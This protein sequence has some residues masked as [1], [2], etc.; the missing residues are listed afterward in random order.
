[1]KKSDRK[2]IQT[3]IIQSLLDWS[4]AEKGY[5]FDRKG[6]NIFND[7]IKIPFYESTTLGPYWTID[8]Q[9]RLT[10]N[11]LCKEILN[12]I[13]KE[14][15]LTNG[16]FSIS[17]SQL[18]YLQNSDVNELLQFN[19]NCKLYYGNYQF[20]IFAINDVDWIVEWYKIYMEKVGWK[21]IELLSDDLKFYSFCKKAFIN[22]VDKGRS[23]K[24]ANIDQQKVIW[25]TLF[26]IDYYA[27]ITSI[28]LGLKYSYPGIKEY[29]DIALE[30]YK[31]GSYYRDPINKLVDHFRG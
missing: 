5:E 18:N 21:L 6:Y 17:L 26:S 11:S 25:D 19:E 12:I 3:E 14:P 29:V 13:Q 23:L 8:P 4:F 24:A 31:N 16:I 10:D 15:F 28:Y 20:E 1:M 2:K 22:F 9:I 27:L 30:Y 7:R